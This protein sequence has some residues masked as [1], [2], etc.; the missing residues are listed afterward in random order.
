MNV[1]TACLLALTLAAC[2][3][4]A[5]DLVP[6]AD[7]AALKPWLKKV[8]TVLSRRAEG[9]LT[10]EVRPGTFNFGWAQCPLPAGAVTPQ[11]AGVYG[12]FRAAPGTQGQLSLMVLCLNGKTSA[13]YVCPAQALLAES[14]GEWLEF[15][16]PLSDFRPEREGKAPLNGGALRAGDRLQINL[17]GVAGARAVAEFDRLRFLEPS[18]AETV[19]RAV[20][21]AGLARMLLPA[22]LCAGAPHPRLLMNPAR[23]Q[24]VRAKASAGGEAQ[25]AYAS[26]VKSADGMARRLE[27]ENPLAQLLAFQAAGDVNSH[28][29]SSQ[30]EGRL[31]AAVVPIEILAAAYRITGEERYGR[32]AA[33]ALA[34]AARNLDA[35]NAM[36]NSGFYYTRTFYVRTLAFG[37]DWLWPLLTPEERRDV[38]TTLLGFVLK[39][40]ADSWTASWGRR[41][42]HRVWNWDPGLVSC[43]GLGLLALEGETS[44]AEKAMLVDL[45][46]HLRD[47]LTLGID[48]D[49]CGHE[50]PNYLAYGIGAGPE[51]AECLREQGRGDLFTETNWQLIAPWL[52]AETLPDRVRWNNLSDCG[53][54]QSAGAVYSYACGRLAGLAA[55]DRAQPGERLPDPESRLE[56]CDFLWQFSEAPGPRRLSYPALASLMG[57]WWEGGP[58]RRI[59]SAR[60]QD[61][62]AYLLFHEPYAAARDPAAL[63]PDAL[64]FRGRGLAVSRTGYGPDA[65]HFAVEAGPHAAGHDQADKGSFTLY[66]YGADLA[67]DSGY[68]NDGEPLKSGS[69]HAHN[70]VLI[71][72]QG[73]PMHWHNQSSGHISGYHHSP[74]LDW[75]RVDAREA[76]NTRYDGEWRPLPAAEPVEKAVRQFL[77][78]RGTNGVPPYLVVM[79]DIRKDGQPAAYTW[80]WHVPSGMRFQGG[81]DRWAAVPFR[82]TGT[83]LTSAPG[84]AQGGARF[85]F[86]APADGRYLLAGLTCAGGEDESK[87]DSF[88][89]SINGGP[90]A[91]WNLQSGKRFGWEPFLPGEPGVTNRLTLRAGESVR[92]DLMAREP[93]AQLGK[94]ALVPE[95]AALTLAPD[96]QPAAGVVL[97]ADEAVLLEPP[98]ARRPIAEKASGVGRLTVFPVNTDARA[99]TNR[100]F[101]TSREG[102]HPRLEHTVRAVEPRFLMV[103]VPGAEDTPLPRVKRLAV[104]GGAGVEIVWEGG[105]TDQIV[106]G[107]EGRT[108]AGAGPVSDGA[109]AFVRHFAGRRTDWAL[110][111]GTRLEIEGVVRVKPS[112]LRVS[113]DSTRVPRE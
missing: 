57:W 108:P 48:A 21:R 87:S 105:V 24:R 22:E 31:T 2:W 98:L 79:D 6:L 43:A 39:I 49:G 65:L 82:L 63:L 23:L 101:E 55:A 8:N 18:E 109:A 19:G 58:G 106:F 83:M 111:D 72:G 71:N 102:V 103:L 74:L 9:S 70:M 12:R 84:R 47:Y 59:A 77:F 28:Q 81:A 54:G 73:Q 92:V 14:R 89:V 86:K 52:V 15:Y 44:A 75:V 110:L 27:T 61:Q 113:T 94:L 53:H 68:G 76:W 112:S 29:R 41:P 100:W 17:N 96:E 4:S 42:L 104:E 1:K 3:S 50:G 38:K 30:L 66:G 25:A 99:V 32:C 34:H 78:V 91:T 36:L 69:S 45:R 80:L 95:N 5:V 51:F 107:E 20:R 33:K 64:H 93:D 97:A 60:P 35:D 67:I 10:M 90:R 16:V 85:I 26:L 46:R 11:T 62:L 56:A 7:D 40:H 37:Y 13:N 88:F